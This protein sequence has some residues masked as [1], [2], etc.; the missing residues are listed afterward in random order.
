MNTLIPA[1][2]YVALEKITCT[3]TE[4]TVHAYT[5]RSA[6][7]C[8]QCQL[9]AHKV[10]S[11]YQRS[12]G[13]LPWE[14]L[15][16]RLQLSARKFFCLN[17]DCPRKVFCERL[18]A[19]L[20][21]YAHRTVRLNQALAWIGFALGGEAG[22]RLALKLGHTV[23]SATLLHRVRLAASDPLA[24]SAVKVLGVDDFAL[25][26]GTRYGTIL[27]DL[28]K[29]RVIDLIQGR[30]A[31]PLA[32]WLTAHPGVE[33]ISRDR[34]PAYQEGATNGAPEAEQVADRF[35]ILKNLTG[36]FEEFLQQQA[37]AIKAHW[38]QVFAAELQPTQIPPPPDIE[39]V[40]PP[41]ASD[42]MRSRA[43]QIK[44][45]QWHAERKARYE[46]V[47]ELKRQGQNIGQIARSLGVSY[48]GVRLLFVSSEYPV[49]QRS[50]R[51]S[52]VEGYDAY[53][54]QRW[55]EGCQNAQQLH[56]ELAAK[57]YSGSR[58]TVW[59]YIYPWRKAEAEA[60][61]KSF[62]APL[63]KPPK[64]QIPNARECAW[65]LLKAET[66]LSE[67]EQ[68]RRA[69][70]LQLEKVKQGHDLVRRFRQLL[71]A[72]KG[73]DLDDWIKQVEATEGAPLKGFLHGLRRD[74]AA[75]RNAFTSPWSNGQTE[76]QVNRLKFIKRQMFGRANF[77]LL[78]ARVL[79]A[80]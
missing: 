35:H 17:P 75:V 41:T 5:V 59:R 49:V 33:T 8:P 36:A 69:A 51:G 63:K 52:V 23:S 31:K 12:A 34:A 79:N 18:P 55:G 32:D 6:A 3:D 39:R 57:G 68:H 28:E 20:E 19:C 54:R 45:Q 27:V 4:I 80:S 77:D 58:V 7:P 43:C 73:E 29:R 10:H 40:V 56:R 44:R 61:G 11:R 25:R 9:H 14:G 64:Q 71:A 38:Q 62:P 50:A 42:Y 48:S 26:R 16:V 46:Q 76:G 30:E 21:K 24:A 47:Q 2:E 70:L 74:E 22:A 60:A 15:R 1:P 65:L 67:G 66:K 37:S 13:D 53:L 72:R 78:R